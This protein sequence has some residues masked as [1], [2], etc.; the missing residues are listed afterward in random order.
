MRLDATS[1]YGRLCSVWEAGL[2]PQRIKDRGWYSVDVY[3]KSSFSFLLSPF[4]YYI[5]LLISPPIPE[6][7]QSGHEYLATGD[8]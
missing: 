5:L 1:A 3:R 4:N 2:H 8:V 7:D 6:F